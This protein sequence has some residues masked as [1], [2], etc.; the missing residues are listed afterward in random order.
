MYESSSTYILDDLNSIALCR[1]FSM[2]I[3]SASTTSSKS[4]PRM[5]SPGRPNADARSP[6][7]ER[8][9]ANALP[10][11]KFAQKDARASIVSILI[12]WGMWGATFHLRCRRLLA[13]VRKASA[14]RITV[15]ASRRERPV[16][17]D[18]NARTAWIIFDRV[19]MSYFIY[20]FTYWKTANPFDYPFC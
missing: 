5:Q 19:I 20:K 16:A 3:N 13:S 17:F 14:S 10:R 8:G 4:S 6:S 12:P 2:Q 9:T 11:D 7:A 15:S 1:P 18:A